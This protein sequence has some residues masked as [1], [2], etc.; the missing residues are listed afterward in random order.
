MKTIIAVVIASVIFF[1]C[2]KKKETESPATSTNPITLTV[3]V[4]SW[5]SL[6]QVKN[7][8]SGYTVQIPSASSKVTDASGTVIFTGIKKGTYTPVI[9]RVNHE[10]VPTSVSLTQ[11]ATVNVP[12][13]QRSSF[14]LKDFS[15]NQVSKD[16][17]TITFNLDKSIP[18]GKECKIAVLTGTTI[19][20]DPTSYYSNDIVTTATSSS[21]TVNIA[22]LPGVK[23]LIAQLD[24]ADFFFVGAV[25]VS[26][27]VYVSNSSTKPILLGDNALYPGNLIF[28]KNWK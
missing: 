16:S 10:Y 5:D 8:Q 14:V 4:T 7:D 1:S 19:T 2:K 12:V 17:L 21:V 28:K 15:A 23:A 18:A 20:M 25:P 9:T 13:A 24:S 3:K 11:S 6:G 22:K 27:G 26:Y